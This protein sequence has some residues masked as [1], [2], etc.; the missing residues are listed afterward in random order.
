MMPH[1]W[2]VVQCSEVRP[3]P[4]LI[5]CGGG[6]C[7]NLFVWIEAEWVWVAYGGEGNGG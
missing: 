3:G 2:Y 7:V 5:V 4:G 6:V 1:V